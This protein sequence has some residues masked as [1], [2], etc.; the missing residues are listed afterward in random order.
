MGRRHVQRDIAFAGLLVEQLGGK[1]RGIRIGVADKDAPPAAV[2][3]HGPTGFFLTILREACLQPL[4]GRGLA[5]Q[6]A[7]T[8]GLG[9][10]HGTFL[11]AKS[12]TGQRRGETV[13]PVARASRSR[14]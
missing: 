1:L 2:Q 3:D 11:D 7:L 10:L 5:A 12:R 4:V 6:Q 9:L 8:V 14:S 13:A